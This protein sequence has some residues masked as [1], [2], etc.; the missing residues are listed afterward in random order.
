MIDNVNIISIEKLLDNK[1]IIYSKLLSDSFG[2]N[3]IKVTTSDNQDF[4]VKYY[5]K[6][7]KHFNAI[8][9]ERRNLNFL[10]SLNL[11]FFP[12][13]YS[14]SNKFLVISFLNNNKLQPNK[15][16]EDLL[17]AIIKLHSFNDNRYGFEF[18]TQIGGLKQVNRR[19]TNWV[20]FFR[21]HRLGYIYE[22]I[23]S[24]ESMEISI[25]KKIE[26]ILANLENYIPKKPMASLLHGDLWE[27]NILFKDNSFIG[28]IDP[29]SFYGHNELEIAYLRWFNPIFIDDNFLEKYHNY[30]NID[31]E[32]LNYEPIYQ[33]Y[34]SLLNVHLWDRKYVQDVKRLLSKV[35]N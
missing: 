18:D 6:L 15:T 25:N 19:S 24:S 20:D 2:I 27:G 9:S 22:L 12:K 14:D 35:K 28:L 17:D 10:N 26:Y 16:N 1:K 31:K 23:N 5:K 30:I 34:Y 4:I 33:L 3:C 8:E 11:K 13:V 21:E 32:Y 29:G 7:N